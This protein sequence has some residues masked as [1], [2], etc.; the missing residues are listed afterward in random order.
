MFYKKAPADS[1]FFRKFAEQS[2][3]MFRKSPK[4]NFGKQPMLGQKQISYVRPM[5]K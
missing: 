1:A 3:P 5:Y 4:F 2:V